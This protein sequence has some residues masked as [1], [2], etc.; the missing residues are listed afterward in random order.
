MRI[1]IYPGTFDPITNGHLDIIERATKLFDRIIVTLARNSSKKPLFS[2]QERVDL[3]K[4]V[5]KQIDTKVEIEVEMFN[6][7]IVDYAIAK[8]ATAIIRGLRAMSDFEYEFQMALV[9]RRLS[10]NDGIS[11]VFLMPHEKYT[12]LNSSIVRELAS[13]GGDI[14]YFVPPIVEKA[15]HAKFGMK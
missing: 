9:N 4:E 2:G 15:I 14:S 1:G 13:Y 7:L 5:I 3:V 10:G 8:K 12:Y 6:G 11:T